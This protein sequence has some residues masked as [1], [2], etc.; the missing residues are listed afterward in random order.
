[1]ASEQR[2]ASTISASSSPLKFITSLMSKAIVILLLPRKC[3]RILDRRDLLVLPQNRRFRTH[4][5]DT[6]L[7]DLGMAL[8][9]MVLNMRELRRILKRR[10]IPVQMSEPLMNVRVSRANIPD[11]RLEVLHINRI[12]PHNRGKQPHICLCNVLPIIVWTLR[13]T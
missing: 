11:I 10:D 5:C 6:E 1:M 7:I 8:S 12:K 2:N 13:L 3:Q 4:R 9:V